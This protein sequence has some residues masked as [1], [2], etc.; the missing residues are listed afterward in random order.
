MTVSHC[1]FPD[2]GIA[3]RLRV[4]P[5]LESPYVHDSD[6]KLVDLIPF[7]AVFPETCE[8]Q[9]GYLRVKVGE[10]SGFVHVKHI[11]W[12]EDGV[13]YK[14]LNDDQWWNKSWMIESCCCSIRVSH[15]HGATLEELE[16]ELSEIG[17]EKK[18]KKQSVS[19]I[20]DGYTYVS[21]EVGCPYA[22][23]RRTQASKRCHFTIAYAA[24][25]WDHH[26]DELKKVLTRV[27]E[28]YFEK[29]PKDR[30]WELQRFRTFFFKDEN[31]GNYDLGECKPLIW[32]TMEELE[33][34]MQQDL[35]EQ[36]STEENLEQIVRRIHARDNLRYN[37]A[38]ERAEHLQ[39][40]R[41]ELFM[42]TPSAGLGNSPELLDLLEYLADTTYYWSPCHFVKPN[43]KL[44]PPCVTTPDRWHCSRQG[45]WQHFP[46]MCK[47][48]KD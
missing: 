17:I 35:I 30:P 3:T 20:L 40:H 25:M 7:Q 22:A 42:D 5:L 36:R 44:R 21:L 45:D 38:K 6:G 34:K 16:A 26:M 47:Q 39:K 11:I 24:T 29:E 32:Y 14:Q 31:S 41:G 33:K 43:G 12:L 2:A 8:L 1:R 48:H 13:R 27:L 23:D 19:C 10:Q 4:S 18:D 46:I 9:S 15:A 37:Q 28:C